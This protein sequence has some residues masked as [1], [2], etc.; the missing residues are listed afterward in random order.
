MD[1]A[2]LAAHAATLHL[3]GALEEVEPLLA[4]APDVR[5]CTLIG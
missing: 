5:R 2:A 4:V 1:E 3:Q